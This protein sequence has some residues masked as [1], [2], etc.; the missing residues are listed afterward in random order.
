[1][2]EKQT[3]FNVNGHHVEIVEVDMLGFD[4]YVD[5]ADDPINLGEVAYFNTW[6]TWKDLVKY[7][8]EQIQG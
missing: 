2:N 4:I 6:P 1:M 3:T 5:H 7:V 8:P